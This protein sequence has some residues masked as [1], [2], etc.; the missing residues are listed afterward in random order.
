MQ[1]YAAAT[2]D[3]NMSEAALMARLMKDAMTAWTYFQIEGNAP[4]M[5]P[6]AAWSEGEGAIGQLHE[7]T[8]WDV[9]S[10]ILATLSAK[11]LGLVDDAELRIRTQNILAYLD[12]TRFDFDGA[13]LPNYRNSSVDGSPVEAGFDSTDMGR[14][15]VALS[16][17]DH[18]TGG[19]LEVK[20]LVQSW[21][22]QGAIKDGSMMDIKDGQAEPAESYVYAPYTSRGYD[23]WSIEHKSP[24]TLPVG[25]A[26]ER[27][28]FLKLVEETGMIA[29]EPSLSEAVEIGISPQ[30][31]VLA[32]TLSEAQQQR[33]KTSG[34]LTAVSEG[35]MDR[36]PWFSYQGY[37]TNGESGE[38]RAD[39][40]DENP[41]WQTKEFV[42]SALMV[43]SK[44]AFL[45]L[46]YQ[47]DEYSLKL[48]EHI[49]NGAKSEQ[50]G[51]S[52][53]IYEKSGK[54]CE[55]YDI[56][57]NAVILEAIAYIKNGRKPLAAV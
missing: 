15:L 38:W 49:S 45:W 56:N 39:A 33:H 3:Q 44:A 34:I 43:S 52:S 17:L 14:L 9:G 50:L 51:F 37:R 31:A 54:R 36:D 24:L 7:L 16:I 29:T 4:S 23:L 22:V 28:R 21:D 46:A 53:G 13:S 10:I 32:E 30:G 12:K 27:R 47:P 48:Y 35:P 8:M 6:S 19:E 11:H 26:S 55:E 57:T 2:P 42:E 25:T 18:A 5:L 1:S 40:L 20:K 41:A